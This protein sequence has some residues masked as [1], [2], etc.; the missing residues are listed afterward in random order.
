MERFYRW[1]DHRYHS[2]LAVASQAVFQKSS[3]LR[4]SV[5]DMG[6]DLLCAQGGND[7]SQRSE[8]PVDLLALF[9]PLA[10]SSGYSDPLRSS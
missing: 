9:E 2:G 10:S 4:V 5:G 6:T 3:K 1:R 8:R 7:I